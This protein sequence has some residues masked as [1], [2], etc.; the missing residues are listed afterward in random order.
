MKIWKGT[1]NLS[2]MKRADKIIQ[3]FKEIYSKVQVDKS[4][5]LKLCTSLSPKVESII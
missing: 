5:E 3:N 4:F 2:F 1:G